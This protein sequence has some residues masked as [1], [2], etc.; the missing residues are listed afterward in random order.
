MI[1]GNPV[2]DSRIAGAV[3][4]R[5][6]AGDEMAFARIVAAYHE[7]MARIAEEVV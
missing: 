3:I 6:A 2:I 7:D 1:V 5:A 4:E